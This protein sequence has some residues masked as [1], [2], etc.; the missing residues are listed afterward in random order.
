MS[1]S[2]LKFA[3]SF[4]LVA[5]VFSVSA[6]ERR[7]GGNYF[8]EDFP[9]QGACI[10]AK[11]PGNNVAMKG[12]AIRVGNDANM[13]WDTDLLRFAAGWTGGYITGKGVV[14]DGGHGAHP[15]IVGEQKFGTRQG[16]GWANAKGE[17]TDNRTE[18]FGPLAHDWCRWDGMYVNGMDVVLAYTVLGTKI[19][20]QPSSLA[21]DGQVA[22]VRT[23]RV[24]GAK[25]DLVAN[26][27]DLPG[28][29]E[30]LD[31][32][33]AASMVA[34]TNSVQVALVGAPKGVKLAVSAGTRVLLHIPKGTKGA[35]FSVVIWG[36]AAANVAQVQK[37]AALV[38][39]NLKWIAEKS[40]PVLSI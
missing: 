17:F 26:L 27:A 5:F 36:G 33:G 39:P 1:R 35:D 6:A 23:F 22:F 32:G 10:T 25:S 37:L 7:A 29:T 14:Y 13:L 30:A 19:Y 8:Q 2:S 9:F 3:L 24:E 20:E 11:G 40:K 34:G 15:A 28:A 38:K 12:F 31:N 4:A 18:P 16:P 21:A